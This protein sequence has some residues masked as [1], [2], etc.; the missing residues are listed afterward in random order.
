MGIGKKLKTQFLTGILVVIP[1]SV[2]IW[3]LVWIFTVIDGI[4]Q[5]ILQPFLRIPGLGFV[6]MI[7]LVYLVG[8]VASNVLGK[9]LIDYGGYLLGRVPI[10]RP[11]YNSI[12]QI[13]DSFSGSGKTTFQ[14]VV[15]VEFPMKGTRTLGFVTNESI[16]ERGEKLLY[17]F[18]PT[19]PNPTSGFLQIVREENTIQVDISI[20]NAMKMIVSGGAV[21]PQ[22]LID[23]LS[24]E[25][26]T[27]AHG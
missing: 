6:I 17:I 18:I 12:K 24:V 11:I 13:V 15:V 25:N 5:P 21:L 9:R 19:A 10:I 2:T 14:R 1:I 3:I 16:D 26:Q 4:L 7:L 22:K 20:E 27:K 8:V 23:K